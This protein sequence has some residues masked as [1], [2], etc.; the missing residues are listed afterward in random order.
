M[1]ESGISWPAIP[2]KGHIRV[3]LNDTFDDYTYIE[4]RNFNANFE[5]MMHFYKRMFGLNRLV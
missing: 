1:I 3:G 5:K 2:V 4:I